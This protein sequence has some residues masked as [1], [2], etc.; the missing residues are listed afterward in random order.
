MPNVKPISD[1]RDYSAVLSDVAV[2]S[3]VFL[4]KNGKDCYAIVDISEQR[5]YE[6][7]KSALRLMCEL[8]KGRKSGEEK[9]WLSDSDVRTHFKERATLFII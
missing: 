7:A 6:K 9:G 4:T 3:P 5:E 1:L 2:G 8:E